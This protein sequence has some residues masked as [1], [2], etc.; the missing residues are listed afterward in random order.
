MKR[1]GTALAAL[2]AT[3]AQPAQAQSPQVMCD[4]VRKIVTA[5]IEPTAFGSV[6]GANGAAALLPS[7]SF[8]EC[9]FEADGPSYICR[10]PVPREQMAQVHNAFG[11]I[12]TQCL[13][14]QPDVEQVEPG[15]FTLPYFTFLVGNRV[16]VGVYPRQDWGIYAEEAWD[17]EFTDFGFDL[18]ISRLD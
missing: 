15:L 5:A 16:S 7:D 11:Q 4:N 9:R 12:L 14:A 6:L 17:E 3:A 18:V 13:Q 1:I 2:L 8:R 10:V